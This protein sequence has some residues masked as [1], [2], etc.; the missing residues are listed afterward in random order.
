MREDIPPFNDVKLNSYYFE[1][2]ERSFMKE[3][4]AYQVGYWCR[5]QGLDQN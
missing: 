1:I 4:L 2:G 3:H 5:V